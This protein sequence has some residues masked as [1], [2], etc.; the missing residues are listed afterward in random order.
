MG[1]DTD[2]R[3]LV[4]R[5]CDAVLRADVDGFSSCWSDDARWLVPGDGEITGRD[6]I[7]AVFARI[8]PS[9]RQCV[10]EVLNGTVSHAGGDD[11]TASWQIRELQWRE[12]GT[13]SEL[14]GV[15]HDTMA[16]DA[17]G[18]LRFTV[19]DFELVYSGPIDGS[20]RLR[21]PRPA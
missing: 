21:A 19:R 17:D 9:Y 7:T 16:R 5:Y 8:R 20:G 4:G 18:S 3:N 6:A 15:Y 10:Q 11:A 12:D 14:I 1:I 2:V 13:V